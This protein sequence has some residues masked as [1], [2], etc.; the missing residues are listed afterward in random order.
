MIFT[1]EAISYGPLLL[2]ALCCTVDALHDDE[3]QEAWLKC[4]LAFTLFG[5]ATLLPGCGWFVRAR[6]QGR[7]DVL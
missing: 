5:T 2:L 1:S 7:R 4:A 6:V 3:A